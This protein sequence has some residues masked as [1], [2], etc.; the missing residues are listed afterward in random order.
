MTLAHSAIDT[1][2][3]TSINMPLINNI[4]SVITVTL[5][6][7]HWFPHQNHYAYD[8]A[9]KIIP[10]YARGKRNLLIY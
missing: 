9:T 2:T 7:G 8:E 10:L 1:W 3:K 4:I 6:Q 5:M